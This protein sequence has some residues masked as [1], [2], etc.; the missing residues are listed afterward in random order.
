MVNVIFKNKGFYCS[1]NSKIISVSSTDQWVSKRDVIVEQ[2][3]LRARYSTFLESKLMRKGF[4][5]V[6]FVLTD[7]NIAY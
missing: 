1:M 3:R 2:F 7:Y 5:W 6:I 4:L